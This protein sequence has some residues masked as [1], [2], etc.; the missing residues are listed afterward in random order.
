MDPNQSMPPKEDEAP[1]Q[2]H[3]FYEPGK[4]NAVLTK[5]IGASCSH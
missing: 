3:T 2:V 5:N 1:K 4:V